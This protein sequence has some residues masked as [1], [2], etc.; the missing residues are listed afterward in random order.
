M[1]VTGV[2]VSGCVLAERYAIEREIGRGGMATVYRATDL[3]HGRA[4]AVKVLNPDLAAVM[5]V[6]RFI[7]EIEITV[8]LTHPNIV[9]VHDSGEWEGL[10]FFVMPYVEGESLERRLARDRTVPMSEALR[11]A[12]QVADA[13]AYAHDQGI[14]HRDIKPA[15][16]LLHAG[17]A[18][19]VDFGIARAVERAT[20]DQR[21]ASG[22]AFGTLGYMSPEQLSNSPTIDG[23]TD[24]YSLG[25]VLFEMLTGVTP[26]VASTR[27]QLPPARALR[28]LAR[29]APAAV[30]TA[31]TRA[32]E[33]DPADRFSS[34]RSFGAALAAAL[35]VVEPPAVWRRVALLVALAAVCVSTGL[36][37]WQYSPHDPPPAD[38]DRT[39]V[40]IAPFYVASSDPALRAWKDHLALIVQQRLDG[41]GP[42]RAL[43][44]S[45]ATHNWPAITD[46]ASALALGRR[47][48][49]GL[50]TFGTLLETGAHAFRVNA[51]ILDVDRNVVVDE[52]QATVSSPG[53]DLDQL[54]AQLSDSLTHRLL[55][56]LGGRTRV[57]A[58]GRGAFGC[59]SSSWPAVRAYLRGEQYYRRSMWDSATTAYMD[60]IAIDSTCALAYRRV[61]IA[62]SWATSDGDSL[63]LAYKL[64]AG[65]NNHG[66]APRDSLLVAADSMSA[67][68]QMANNDSASAPM[69]WRHARRLIATLEEAARR[70]PGDP[71]VW[72]ALGDAGYHFGWGP[73]STT[74]R[75]MLNAFDK[76]IALDSGFAPSYL[77]PIEIGFAVGGD[78]LALRYA[79]AYLSTNPTDVNADAARIVVRLVNATGAT[80][81]ATVRMLD[82]ASTTALASAR[83]L[84][85]LRRDSLE[86][87]VRLSELLAAREGADSSMA[88]GH[89]RDAR[90]N[91]ARRLARRGHLSGARCALGNQTATR[92]YA[93]LA[94]L[95][96]IPADSATREF[97]RWLESEP[98]LIAFALP[99]WYERGDTARL[100]RVL[101]RAR[102]LLR[103]PAGTPAW[104]RA[105]YDSAAAL[106]YIA[107]ARR[108]DRALARFMALPDSLC[109]KCFDLDRLRV[110]QLLASEGRLEEARA[111]VEEWRG[112]YEAPSDMLFAL[113]LA[114]INEQLGDREAAL[115]A[116]RT[117]VEAWPAADSVLQAILSEA[118]DGMRRV[119]RDGTLG[120]RL[121][122]PERGAWSPLP[123]SPTGG[124]PF[125]PT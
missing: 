46:R 33:S 40:A 49:A 44:P 38:V 47:T 63:V 66:L 112:P 72:Y 28:K 12:G 1:Q 45:V 8:H 34:A 116:Y 27:H 65:M 24:I 79:R 25:C 102:Q 4:V 101:H 85:D 93:E 81:A 123:G 84:V 50:V 19:V 48:G 98:G 15:N 39:L 96:G 62:R 103:G 88:A 52:V 83:L 17:H 92:L 120:V 119:V 113:E 51:E 121:I 71:E 18:V 106:A 35:T 21:T 56:R 82:S 60:A 43:S 59:A 6:Q 117:I 104:H 64:R 69:F 94:L 30:V 122:P 125:S 107:L 37:L 16:I 5:G 124:Q 9:G 22:V 11:I 80:V 114:R 109:L 110:A 26:N 108:D 70:Y 105:A 89:C 20:G 32:L 87:A 2:L 29:T 57:V 13:L 90:P 31:V 74:P 115:S 14:I 68:V 86:S 54:L 58:V 100:E 76:A 3:R 53:L 95:G 41:A 111:I 55:E 91:F 118:R 67:V 97:D 10:P 36:A 73:T 42:L 75:E 23:R 7:Q 78:S 77:H 61:A 99:W